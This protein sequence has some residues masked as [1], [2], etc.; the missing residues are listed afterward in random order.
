[1]RVAGAPLHEPAALCFADVI[2]GTRDQPGAGHS[3]WG[4]RSS[5]TSD[6][7]SVA[8]CKTTHLCV[9][10]CVMLLVKKKKKKRVFTLNFRDTSE[11]KM[12]TKINLQNNSRGR[13]AK[14]A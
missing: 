2:L 13:H 12:T 5:T 14:N 10:V 4:H 9:C 3:D 6:C 1:M 7:S 8:K 11:I